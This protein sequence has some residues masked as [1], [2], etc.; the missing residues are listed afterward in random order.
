M[1][2]FVPIV[3]P[4]TLANRDLLTRLAVLI[5]LEE[6]TLIFKNKFCSFYL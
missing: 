1:L 6:S 3:I 2:K 4:F 5:V